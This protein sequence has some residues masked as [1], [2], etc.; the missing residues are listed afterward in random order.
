MPEKRKVPI[1]IVVVLG[2][3]GL[4]AI[5]VGVVLYLGVVGA[6]RNTERLLV[7]K[8]ETL[9]DSME[10][11]VKSILAPVREQSRWIA[12][13]ISA[14][15]INLD[16]T[17]DLDQFMRGVLA[18]TPQ[19]AGIAYTNPLGVSRRWQRD[20][21]MVVE[22][23]WSGRADIRAWLEEGE[24]QTAPL[25]RRPFWTATIEQTVVLHDIPL[26]QNGEFLGMIGQIVPVSD[27]SRQFAVDNKKTG[28]TPFILYDR[29]SVLAHPQ[30]ISWVVDGVDE[31][32]PLPQLSELGD[33]VLEG[34]WNPDEP[35]PFFFRGHSSIETSGS[36]FD[37]SYYL[38]LYRHISGYGQAPWTIGAYVNTTIHGGE[39]VRRLV[40]MI[41]VGL[42]FLLLS[43][44]IAIYAG[45]RISRPIQEIARASNLVKNKRY[46]EV[47][48]LEPS[49]I[50][51][52]ND[53]TQSFN[54]MVLG[55]RER[56][57]VR[58]TLGRL[59]PEEVARSLLLEGGRL[60]PR[61]VDGTILF[62]DIEQFTAL[63]QRLGPNGIVTTLN[64]FFTAM[65]EILERHG[66]VVT[67]FQGD[68]MLATFNV[69]LENKDHATN[70][71][72]AAEEMQLKASSEKFTGESLGI[73]IGINSGQFVAGLVGAEGRLSYTV[74]GDAVNLAARLEA[75]NKEY[76]TRILVSSHTADLS[77][78]LLLI[79]TGEANV[80][81][82]SKPVAIFELR[83]RGN[84]PNDVKNPSF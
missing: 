10:Q 34:I 3:G 2:L 35:D 73:R 8:S 68:A 45:R 33:P 72:K 21:W 76:G 26:R 9:I 62:C 23:D 61:Q 79:P 38:Y 64:S 40:G 30:Y 83:A 6:T 60:E 78:G 17:A 74:H 24:T 12:A 7:D 19:V 47:P 57:L 82:L 43:V 22:E 41:V 31:D 1:S 14:G 37:D 52:F 54:Q 77:S 66:G 69:P 11:R 15:E 75:M 53:A 58:Q 56:E 70:A 48:T 55:L 51:E 44:V 32:S 28:M 59:V 16:D 39:E 29:Q 20:P 81:G 36:S 71:L 42:A 46:S 25:W 49:R 50:S 65:V 13:V 5:T 80:R 67:Q 84:S 18:A 27:L 4:V 63:T